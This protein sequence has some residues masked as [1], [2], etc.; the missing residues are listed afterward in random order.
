VNLE[1][2][3][4]IQVM[5]TKTRIRSC[6]CY[7]KSVN[8]WNTLQNMTDECEIVIDRPQGSVHPRHSDYI[9]PFDYGYLEGT[10]SGDGDGIDCWVG[11]L[12]G[13]EISGVV[14]VVDG[15]KKD[16]EIKILIG[17]TK[18]DM[19]TILGCHNRGA[20]SGIL[21]VRK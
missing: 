15:F 18:E 4:R 12:G 19:Q 14:T 16:S 11:S 21:Q 3:R 6:F 10:T 2:P 17:C 7:T 1:T 13:S 20:M 8:F 9:Y 5:E